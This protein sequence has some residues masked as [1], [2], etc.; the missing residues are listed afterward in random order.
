MLDHLREDGVVAA[1]ATE[2]LEVIPSL[3]LEFVP[4][5]LPLLGG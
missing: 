4:Q 5:G 3:L 1:E 2:I